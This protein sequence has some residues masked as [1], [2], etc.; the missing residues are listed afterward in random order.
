VA[1][2][3]LCPPRPYASGPAAALAF[4]P[5]ILA[6]ENRLDLSRDGRDTAAFAGYQDTT[7]TFY[8]LSVNDN[9][10]DFNGRGGRGSGGTRDD[11]SRDASSQSYGTSSR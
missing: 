6:G 1:V 9:F 10:N 11:Y 5:P 2:K 4:D 8:F 3:P 7:T